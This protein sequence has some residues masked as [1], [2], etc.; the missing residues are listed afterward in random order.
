LMGLNRNPNRTE[1]A[2][3]SI[4][5]LNLIP[6]TRHHQTNKREPELVLCPGKSISQLDPW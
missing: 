1:I 6:G 2:I 3:K 4:N 5:K